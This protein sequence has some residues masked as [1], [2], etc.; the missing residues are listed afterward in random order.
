VI[1]VKVFST[2]KSGALAATIPPEMKADGYLKNT[3]VEWVKQEGGWM[4]KKATS[5]PPVEKVA[6]ATIQPTEA[7]EKPI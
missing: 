1:Y 2:N 3:P 7:A 5:S 4:L 6:S